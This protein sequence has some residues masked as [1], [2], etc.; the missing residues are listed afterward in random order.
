MRSYRCQDCPPGAGEHPAGPRGPLPV[1]C[2]THRAERE[3]RRGRRRRSGLTV[4]PDGATTPPP[5][6]DITP[7]PPGLADIVQ[8]DLDALL[9]THPARDSLV[10]LAGR[11]ALAVDSPLTLLDPRA[12][13]ALVR[14][15]RATV[16]DLVDHEEAE[17]DDLFGDDGDVPTAVV[18]AAA[19][20]P[21]DVGD[22]AG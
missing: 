21:P 22:P 17:D 10:A 15:L 4:V 5:V 7:A 8:A 1:R 14:E 11:L 18:D 6:P 19:A 3:R 12:L 9:S 16:R 2:P 13:P 20:R